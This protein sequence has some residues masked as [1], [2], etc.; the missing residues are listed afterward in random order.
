MRRNDAAGGAAGQCGDAIET[1][2]FHISYG[3]SITRSKTTY[4]WGDAKTGTDGGKKQGSLQK[5]ET[6]S[7]SGCEGSPS[8]HMQADDNKRED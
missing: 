6:S 8:V 2:V 5:A 1:V 7:L 4:L 3:T